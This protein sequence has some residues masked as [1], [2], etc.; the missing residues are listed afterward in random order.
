MCGCRVEQAV[1]LVQADEGRLARLAPVRVLTSPEDDMVLVCPFPL[2]SK[3]V[4]VR[5]IRPGF[6][7]KFRECHVHHATE[8]ANATEYYYGL[9]VIRF[10]EWMLL[11]NHLQQTLLRGSPPRPSMLQ[12]APTPA[13]RNEQSLVPLLSAVGL[14]VVYASNFPW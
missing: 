3:R 10:A 12:P 2:N 14:V 9:K 8:A 6:D 5:R 13:R 11:T 1:V 7:R 4:W